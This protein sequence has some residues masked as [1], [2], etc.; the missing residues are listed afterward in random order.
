MPCTIIHVRNRLWS[1]YAR[2]N[3]GLVHRNTFKSMLICGQRNAKKD[4]NEN[5][6]KSTHQWL[7]FQCC[8]SRNQVET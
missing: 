6:R 2:K 8:R 4:I 3:C 7:K 5:S 1:V